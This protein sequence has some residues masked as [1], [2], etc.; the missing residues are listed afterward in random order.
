MSDFP[1]ISTSALKTSDWELFKA[2]RS[3]PQIRTPFEGGA[4]Q[5]RVRVSTS[6]WKFQVGA[7]VM[8]T[9]QFN[10]LV[11]HFDTNQG[12]VFSFVHPITGNTHTVRYSDDELPEVN[13]IGD[14]S[15]ARWKI[16]GINLEEYIGSTI[17]TQ[18][19]SSTTT[20]SSSTVSS[21]STT[22]TTGP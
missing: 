17:E 10:A 12:G 3:R 18:T 20:T 13:P 7:A 14:G 4:V 19:T 2:V 1:L 5:T 11:S 22:T 8:T 16:E 15:D 6:R 21:S 9:T